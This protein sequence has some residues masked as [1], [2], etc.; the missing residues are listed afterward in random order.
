LKRERRPVI[1]RFPPFVAP[2]PYLR[3]AQRRRRALALDRRWLKYSLIGEP[4]VNK[5]DASNRKSNQSAEG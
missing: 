5:L 2:H 3:R 4:S 1:R